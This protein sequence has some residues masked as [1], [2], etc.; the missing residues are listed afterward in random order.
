MSTSCPLPTLL[1]L[2][3][4]KYVAPLRG[5]KVD[6]VPS[7]GEYLGLEQIEPWTG[8]LSGVELTQAPEGGA[9]VF[10][11][12]DVLFGKLRPYL[13]KA[14]V[15]NRAGYCTTESLVLQPA[16]ADSRFIRYCLLTPEA[17]SAIDG[18]TYGTKMPR[19]DWSFIGALQLP[20]PPLSEQTRIANFLD[21]Q[22]ARIDAL[23]AEKERLGGLLG[24]YRASLISA[25]VTGQFEVATGD[26]VPGTYERGCG[27]AKAV[28]GRK[29]PPNWRR[30]R[31]R[32]IARF[33]SGG[34]PSKS[35]SM[36]WQGQIPWF[37]PKDFSSGVLVDSEDHISAEAVE[38]SATMM[39]PAGTP[40]FVVRSGI[41]RHTIP[42][43]LL[44][45]DGCINQDVK[46]VFLKDEL[47]P[48]YF[49]YVVQGFQGELIDEWTKQGAT[50]E[51]I[52]QQFV[53]N[54]SFPVP[55]RQDQTRIANFLDE[56]TARIDDLRSHCEE[57]ISLLREYRVSLISAAVTGQLNIENFGRE[58][59]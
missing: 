53:D 39:L 6:S 42:I 5:E 48:R 21:E 3:P 54:T 16:A 27:T 12:G 4:L 57:H 18:S 9:N 30:M 35:N 31:L 41:L 46:G 47:I 25:A 33:I 1:P 56:K 11:P 50:V 37:S 10:Y 59:A 26:V 29:L 20:L 14:W 36:F 52:E 19:A 55:S 15:A 58:V 49:V 51:S 22:T 38:A 23:I 28:F 34:T 24:E 2:K 17:I 8:K 13:A 7:H 32:H 43:A 40:V 44:D 45:V